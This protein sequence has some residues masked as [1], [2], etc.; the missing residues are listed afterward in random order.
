MLTLIL[1]IVLNAVKNGFNEAVE[2]IAGKYAEIEIL[3]TQIAALEDKER[4]IL[5][6]GGSA[7]GEARIFCIQCGAPNKIGGRFCEKCGS[8]FAE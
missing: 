3:K 4:D 2:E 8:K 7:S 6:N 1:L 5:G